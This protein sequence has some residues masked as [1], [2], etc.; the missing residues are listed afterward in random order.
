MMPEFAGMEDCNTIIEAEGAASLLAYWID[1]GPYLI[2]IGNIPVGAFGLNL[3]DDSIT[4][5]SDTQQLLDA[6]AY[7]VALIAF[8]MIRA[9]LSESNDPARLREMARAACRHARL[10]FLTTQRMNAVMSK[11]GPPRR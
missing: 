8:E 11:S 10:R 9:R 1:S 2:L 3:T 6:H 7:D 5:P 4:R